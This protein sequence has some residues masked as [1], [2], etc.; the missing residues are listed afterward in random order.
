[1]LSNG[2]EKE[3]LHDD[4]LKGKKLRSCIS[5]YSCVQYV[6]RGSALRFVVKTTP[7]RPS[8]SI[9]NI[10]YQINFI[11]FRKCLFFLFPCDKHSKC[12]RRKGSVVETH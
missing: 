7:V 3:L 4:W 8:R 1:M 2:K 9:D 12:E 5:E 11:S 10:K 6:R